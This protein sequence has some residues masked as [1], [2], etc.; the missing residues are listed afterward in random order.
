MHLADAPSIDQGRRDPTEVAHASARGT[1]TDAFWMEPRRQFD[2][3]KWP[4]ALWSLCNRSVAMA[5]VV[6]GAIALSA[7]LLL[8]P[9][10]PLPQP[11]VHD[12]FS[13]LLAADTFAHGRLTNPAHPMWIHF[14]T[15]HVLSLPTYA[16]KY[17]P[18]Q[19]LVLALGQLFNA[20][21]AALWVSMAVFCGLITWA[22]WAC[23]PPR[24]AIAAG[25]LAALQLT[26]GY[27]TESYWG[28]TVAAIGGALVVGALVRLLR[29]ISSAPAVALGVGL[30]I[31]A[32]TRPYEGFILGASCAGFLLMH[33]V[34]IVRHR[35]RTFS[36]LVRSIG[37]PVTAILVPTFLWMGYYNYRVTG[38]PL[39]MPY[40][41]YEDRYSPQ[42]Q[43]LWSSQ[44]RPVATYNHE[45]LRAF[46]IGFDQPLKQF[47]YAHML[48]IHQKN[49][50]DFYHFILGWPLLLCIV[51]ASPCLVTNRRLRIPL[52]LTL[53]FYL[54]LAPET[55]LWP[56]YFAPATVLVF[57]IVTAAVR[58]V[59]LLFPAG[60][61][62]TAATCAIFCGL[63]IFDVSRIASVISSQRPDQVT[64]A[65]P[66]P[67]DR[68]S[69]MAL[70][71]RS[72]P[73]DD[74]HE[75]IA[76]R[77]RWITFLRAQP[78]Q[79]LVLVRYGPNHDVHREWVYNDADIDHSRIV[80]ARSMP[81]G[82]DQ[83]LLRYYPDRHVWILDAPE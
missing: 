59:A 75:F 79:H 31:L 38:S 55:D 29:R 51:V 40:F 5:S 20:P 78:G 42:S 39:R 9:L 21:W 16:S 65:I 77:R 15:F 74:A 70:K 68:L 37:L 66:A 23:L 13:Y 4:A 73:R 32:N 30:A 6:V 76:Q 35:R 45:V 56:H 36:D 83:E 41:V 19:G 47:E 71:A 34:S 80:W 58:E 24:W 49:L 62:R 53:L 63:A 43:F 48:Q 22:L 33:L 10:L 1:V 44:P 17:P 81:G 82:K 54:G 25:L 8:T 67:S 69:F 27:W 60:K 7:R 18:G 11:S 64:E 3:Q 28:G 52:L 2:F 61:M 46:W 14:E 72:M 57:L 12:E 26:G 50:L